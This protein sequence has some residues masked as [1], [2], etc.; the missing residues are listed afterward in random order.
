MIARWWGSLSIQI[1]LT[2]LIQV[3][4]VLILAFAQRWVM[5]SFESK[6]MESAQVR[7]FDT[8]EGVI[9][10]MNM[11]MLTGQ[12]GDPKV[13]SLFIEKM[14]KSDGVKELR[15]FRAEQVKKQFGMGLP[16]EQPKDEIDQSVLATGKPYFAIRDA[17]TH[18]LRAVIPFIA[19]HDFKGTDC[20][21]CHKVEVGSVNGAAN[22]VLD[23]T[24]ETHMIESINQR[25]WLGQL[26]LQVLLFF[27]IEI[28]LRSFT[29]P[30]I[31]LEEVMTA[32]QS[33]GDLSRRV[34]I[35]GTDEIGRMAGAFNALA[36]SLQ[37][38]VEQVKEG[39]EKLRLSAQVF[40]N[41][42]EA[43]VITD[44]QNNIIQVNKAFTDITGYSEEEVIG[45]NPSVLK[46]GQQG[47]EFYRQ[48]W[49][50]L[51]ETGCWQ[52]E[53]MDRRKSGEIYPKWLSI[54]VVRDEQGAITNYIALFSDITE[55]KASFDRIQHLA[56]YDALTHLPNRA[57]LSDHIDLAI[58][59]AKRNNSK[60]AV[61]FLD[62][63]R[64]KIVNDT[65]GHHVGDTLLLAVAERLQ[66]CVRE[67][68][69]VARLGGDEFVI[70]L[71]I[72]NED[73][74]AALVAQK[75]IDLIG[76]PFTLGEYRA[77]IGTSIGISIYPAHGADKFTLLKHADAAMYTAKEKG[78]NNF[79]FYSGA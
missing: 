44:I 16:E 43:I 39:Q 79:Q 22:I 73:Q 42:A 11:L 15:I 71:N 37:K 58:A 26:I 27:V 52:G 6:I 40:V 29:R 56:H 5:S 75:V 50:V 30:V 74:D 19:S 76:K 20:L 53:I 55:R 23:V 2:L 45:K 63:D 57:L 28:M 35:A 64:F 18:T 61:V 21:V 48:M 60:L 78:R 24:E 68:D 1:K 69:T 33:D 59:G 67:S 51:L 70:L 54:A 41:S 36:E 10:G 4:L 46:S 77:E 62:L 17:Q 31:K 49:Q 65:M 66:Q 8:A 38:S 32:M 47:R 34:D 12:I 13:R 72:I 7:A 14:G 25:L 9:N 3:S